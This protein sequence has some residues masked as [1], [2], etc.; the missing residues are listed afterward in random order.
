MTAS[1]RMFSFF[2]DAVQLPLP[3]LTTN[4][5]NQVV[6]LGHVVQADVQKPRGDHSVM[7]AHLPTVS[8]GKPLAVAGTHLPSFLADYY[9]RIHI[10]LSLIALGNVVSSQSR[11]VYIWNAW[12]TKSVTLQSL[13]ATN[14]EGIT[15]GQP[16]APPLVYAILQERIYTIA[17]STAGPPVINS[18][19]NWEFGVD[20]TVSVN[21]TGNR[22]TA[23]TIGPDWGSQLT[24]TFE[25][26]T[27]LERSYDGTEVRTQI[28][29]SPRR[30]W[31]YT[32][33]A[34]YAGATFMDNALFAWNKRIWALPVWTDMQ[35][36]GSEFASGQTVL[37]CIT[38]DLDFEAGQLAILISDPQT[39][40]VL[41]VLSVQTT[42]LTLKN[43]L[44][45]DWVKGTKLYPMRKAR[46]TTNPTLSRITDNAWATP[47]SF[48]SAEA[49]PYPAYTGWTLY[50][51]L[52]VLQDQMDWTLD[53][54]MAY[55][56]LSETLDN[57]TGLPAV[58]ET[59]GFTQPIQGFQWRLF[60]KA[61]R[62]QLK[63]TLAYMAGRV[64][65][66]WLPTWNSDLTPVLTT[67]ASSVVLTVT[68]VGYTLFNSGVK[69]RRDIRIEL[70]D[71][72]VLYRRILNST[73][74]LN[75]TEQLDMD[76]PLGRTTAPNQFRRISY[77]VPVRFDTDTFSLVYDTDAI[78][79]LATSFR[80][81]KDSV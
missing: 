12:L 76:S 66:L 9:N 55:D 44:S 37:P 60:T 43:G 4:V 7:T 15:V 41:Q 67:S 59:G 72:T 10:S 61:A 27:D 75:G 31:A 23:W 80:G 35:P 57:A 73:D 25:Y 42:G 47:I 39:Y 36:I 11:S 62:T 65:V 29:S 69:N 77:M 2:A 6:N 18:T 64:G 26:L 21:I 70:F 48:I 53:P 28:R 8:A 3:A 54:Q 20:G 74:L 22:V 52:P 81:V 51:G 5:V 24:E 1:A 38:A 17:A 16:E 34:W 79:S 45:D 13:D 50:R 30:S 19:L 78:T 71:N 49:N 46:L 33:F 56:R 68:N 14:A 63:G 32:A 40:E 58:Y